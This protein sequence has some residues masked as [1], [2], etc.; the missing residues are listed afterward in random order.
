VGL[1]RSHGPAQLTRAVL[2]G[3]AFNLATCIDAFRE[4]GQ[5][6][7]RIDAIGG[8]AASG[9]WLQI[10][11]DVWGCEVRRRSVV[12]EANSLGAA[13]TAGVGTGLFDDFSV[14]RD[15]SEVVSIFQP[16]SARHEAYR[17]RHRRFVNAYERLEPWFAPERA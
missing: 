4:H 16:D 5:P 17:I 14:A 11:A 6:V 8:G 15:L 1:G 13:I 2:E 10:L 12:E 7:A 3:V 9:I